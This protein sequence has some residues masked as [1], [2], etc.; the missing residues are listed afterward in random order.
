MTTTLAADRTAEGPKHTAHTA[1]TSQPPIQPPHSPLSSA[2]TRHTHT[3]EI[4]PQTMAQ[5]CH[6]ADRGML[7]AG[8]RE[9]TP[10][11]GLDIG[12]G[13]ARRR[14]GDLRSGACR[15]ARG[16]ETQ[17]RPRDGWWRSIALKTIGPMQTDVLHCP[18]LLYTSPSPRDRSVSRMPSSA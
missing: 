11:S 7:A 2:H 1:H 5:G 4:T 8:L 18:C 9:V 16:S 15:K 10:S 14:R 13:P 17:A 12:G 6:V 3:I